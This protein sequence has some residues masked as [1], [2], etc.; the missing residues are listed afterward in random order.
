MFYQ[1][2]EGELPL[3]KMTRPIDLVKIKQTK[4]LY[5]NFGQPSLEW[6]GIKYVDL[7]AKAGDLRTSFGEL[8]L[9]WEDMRTGMA[10]L[11]YSEKQII[12]EQIHLV[13]HIN[14]FTQQREALVWVEKGQLA[15]Q[16]VTVNFYTEVN[17]RPGIILRAGGSSGQEVGYWGGYRYNFDDLLI[18]KYVNGTFTEII[19]KNPGL[20]R[21]KWYTLRMK[22]EGTS[23]YLKVREMGTEEPPDWD[24]TTVDSSITSGYAGIMD[25]EAFGESLW[26]NFHLNGEEANW[27]TSDGGIPDGWSLQFGTASRWT[28]KTESVPVGVDYLVVPG[29]TVHFGGQTSQTNQDGMA[30][31]FDL[32]ANQLYDYEISHP[33]FEGISKG[34]ILIPEDERE[35]IPV[36]IYDNPWD[37]FAK[38]RGIQPSL[39]NIST[40]W[41]QVEF[42]EIKARASG[43]K[44]NASLQSILWVEVESE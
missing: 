6:E 21:G 24:L 14:N 32:V 16:D 18:S 38:G 31:F 3:Y 43:V 39:G 17:K 37:G 25:F 4:P 28:T 42:E 33:D 8:G 12:Y 41:H 13:R 26:S 36:R 9:E 27:E 40:L 30:E 19:A 1:E 22:A 44:T 11:V 15:N 2:G 23:L 34:T 20:V 29:A 5:T 10:V 35:F 7:L